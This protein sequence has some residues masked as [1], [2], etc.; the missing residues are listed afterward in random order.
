MARLESDINARRVCG[1][2]KAC[3]KPDSEFL[4]AAKYIRQKLGIAQWLP[5]LFYFFLQAKNSR[6]G[7]RFAIE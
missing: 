2:D 6:L 7:I 1:I 5:H 3:I 4:A